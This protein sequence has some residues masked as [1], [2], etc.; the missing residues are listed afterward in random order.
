MTGEQGKATRLLLV[1][2]GGVQ[3]VTADFFGMDLV[4]EVARLLGSEH[5]RSTRLG[6][7]LTLWHAEDGPGRARSGQ[8]NPV[9]SRLAAEHGSPPVAGPAVVTGPILYGSPYPLDADEAERIA[10]RLR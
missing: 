8:P 9:A 7:D 5:I 10:T 6:D 4:Q 3:Q 1:N 2:I